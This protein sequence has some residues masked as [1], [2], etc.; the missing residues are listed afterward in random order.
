MAGISYFTFNGRKSTDFGLVIS[1]PA[2]T[3]SGAGAALETVTIPGRSGVLTISS[4]RREETEVTY[5]VWGKAG[6][7]EE[8]AA[9]MRRIKGW[10]L[11]GQGSYYKLTDT[12]DPDYYWMAR[13]S[14]NVVTSQEFLQIISMEIRFLAYPYKYSI[15]G[16][17]SIQ[18]SGSSL[19][20]Y[21]LTNPEAFES[22]PYFKITGKGD[23]TLTVNGKSWTVKGVTNYVEM[24]SAQMNTFVG[25][26]S[27]NN[28]KTGD[29]YPILQAG[30][31][32]IACSNNV[33]A[34]EIIPRWCTL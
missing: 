28:K 4:D 17:R 2:E 6:F 22:R 15:E 18:V 9:F 19:S 31:N 1:N 29:G 23:V 26:T 16:S 14:G 27:Y 10:L 8:K 5:E 11:T 3:V 34:L 20:G 21:S 32:S 7:N 33:T 12:Y 30:E 25:D 24:D 13:Y